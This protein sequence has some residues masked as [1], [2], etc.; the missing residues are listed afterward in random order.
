M[1]ILAL[2]TSLALRRALVKLAERESIV[3]RNGSQACC[4]SILNVSANK[5]TRKR[6][7]RAVH[8]FS[9]NDIRCNCASTIVN[10]LREW[11]IE[12]IKKTTF[13]K[14]IK[15][16]KERNKPKKTTQSLVESS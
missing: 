16:E 12:V 11:K 15:N 9:W 2:Q 6:D 13:L 1:I 10:W 5:A 8:F 7:P 3:F 4:S 14:I